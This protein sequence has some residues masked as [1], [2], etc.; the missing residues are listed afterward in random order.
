[1]VSSLSKLT[2]QMCNQ[3]SQQKLAYTRVSELISEIFNFSTALI[4]LQRNARG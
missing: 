2:R 1:M 4:K 3:W